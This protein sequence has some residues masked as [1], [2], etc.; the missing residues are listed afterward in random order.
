V[1]EVASVDPLVLHL[2]ALNLQ[3]QQASAGKKYIA[4]R[5]EEIHP[6]KSTQHSPS[7]HLLH[8]GISLTCGLDLG[9]VLILRSTTRRMVQEFTC[10]P[11][12]ECRSPYG[13]S[14]DITL[15]VVACSAAH[16]AV[17]CPSSQLPAPSRASTFRSDGKGRP[18]GGR[19]VCAT[20]Y[21]RVRL[22]YVRPCLRTPLLTHVS[23]GRS[24][25]VESEAP[26]GS[27][28]PRWRSAASRQ[29]CARTS[30]CVPH[31]RLALFVPLGGAFEPTQ[32]S[33]GSRG[34]LLTTFA[35]RKQRG[36]DGGPCYPPL[37]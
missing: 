34:E 25:N 35:H 31:T 24:V 16:A 7:A 5:R 1:L 29:S 36:L 2:L 3:R 30:S 26:L 27:R 11:S 13:A 21:Q 37:R 22:R 10:L 19:G 32:F 17:R 20:P 6:P 33:P 15:H 12:R 9:R 28:S 4:Q 18:V 8:P 23:L 14:Y